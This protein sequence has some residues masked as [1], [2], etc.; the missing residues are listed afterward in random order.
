MIKKENTAFV[1]PGQGAQCP[2]MGLDI[3]KS[4]VEAEKIFKKAELLRPGTIKQ[5]FEGTKEEL[6]L[7][8]NTQPCIFTVDVAM[9]KACQQSGI[10]AGA[11]AGFSLGELA[12]L[13]VAS[14]FE[15]E[16]AFNL[17]CHRA[18]L[19][20][21]SA[22]EN[23]GVMY[24]V[25]GLEDYIVEA[26]CK[27]IGDC[28]P[29]NY[30]CPGQIVV[31]C[32]DNYEEA[33]MTEIR[34]VNGRA[35]KLAVSGAFHSPFMKMSSDELR[36][37]LEN[38]AF[39]EPVVPVYSNKT[40]CPYNGLHEDEKKHILAMQLSSP[41]LWKNIISRMIEDGIDTFIEVGPGKVLCGLISKINPNVRVYHAMDFLSKG[42]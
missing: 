9:A 29:V 8:Q 16:N 35:R 18:N 17:I 1:F 36:R 23:P 41:V 11:Y 30:N 40:A 15:F 39:N 25:L 3:F 27:S 5:C 6:S 12:A 28:Y 10:E 42:E 38:V 22:S 4:S 2:G 37:Y 32:R 21:R 14:A 13:H 34:N 31:A 7:T 20:S 24:A 19:M 33:F 26:V